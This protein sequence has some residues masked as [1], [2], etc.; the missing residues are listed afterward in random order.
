MSSAPRLW[1]VG[2]ILALGVVSISTAA[3]FIRLS[4]EAAGVRGVGFS[5]VLAA[6][7]LILASLMLLPAWK[8][9]P[10]S[11][12]QAW[13]YAGAAGV[14]LAIHFA[15]W[16][17]SLSYTSIVASTTL[18]TTNPIW[19]ALFSWVGFRETPKRLTWVG[20]GIALMGGLAIAWGEPHSQ[21]SPHPWFGNTLA[22]IGAWCA[23]LYLLF[24]REAQRH[25][26]SITS[27]AVIAYSSAALV[28]C[29][30]PLLWGMRYTGYPREVYLYIFLMALFS[31][32]IGHTSFNWA[33]RWISPTFV[34]LAILFEPVGSSVLGYLI[35]Q[36]VP[37]RGVLV[38]AVG[39]LMGVAIA[40]FSLTPTSS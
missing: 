36:E 21:I 31:Q 29:P 23:S 26:L 27:Y 24:G 20:I 2:F 5:L 9:L 7:R 12:P 17:A 16:I 32:V 18:V 34:T 39:I 4:L 1:Q 8:S 30:L 40:A 37:S 11:T 28:L 19:V 14:F 33:V 35:F 38:G 3:I 22:L 6:S 13:R 25:G 10:P 15:T